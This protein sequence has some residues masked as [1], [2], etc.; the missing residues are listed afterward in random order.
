MHETHKRSIVKAISYRILGT[1]ITALIV[2][3]FTGNFSVSLGVAGVELFAKSIAYYLHERIWN[4]VGRGKYV[5][6][7]VPA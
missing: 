5:H 1:I 6:G 2:F 4:S 7:T 3:V